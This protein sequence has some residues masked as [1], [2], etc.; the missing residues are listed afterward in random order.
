MMKFMCLV[1][2]HSHPEEWQ[3]IQPLPGLHAPLQA[4]RS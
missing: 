2:D 4:Y 3:D 1:S